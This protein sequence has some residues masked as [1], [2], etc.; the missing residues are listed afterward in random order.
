MRLDGTLGLGDGTGQAA[1]RLKYAADGLRGSVPE[2]PIN[3]PL[4][5]SAS[6]PEARVP[7]RGI[8]SRTMVKVVWPYP[9]KEG[10]NAHAC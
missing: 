3:D 8:P 1:R 10:P 9:L 4:D 7:L 6:L 2:R 5:L